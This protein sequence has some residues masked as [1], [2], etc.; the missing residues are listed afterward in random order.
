VHQWLD[1][2]DQN[3]GASFGRFWDPSREIRSA[4]QTDLAMIS[5]RDIDWPK[6]ITA[7][8][9][10]GKQMELENDRARRDETLERNRDNDS[11]GGEEP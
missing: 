9:W 1:Y 7:G 3:H 8:E 2:V 11:G 5:G 4:I 10:V 6:L